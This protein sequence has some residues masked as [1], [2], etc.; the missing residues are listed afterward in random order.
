MVCEGYPPSAF[1][2]S[3]PK[4]QRSCDSAQ[5]SSR[6]RLGGVIAVLEVILYL[7]VT[8]AVSH[9]S[10]GPYCQN[11]VLGAFC[12]PSSVVARPWHFLWI[13]PTRPGLFGSTN[14]PR[15]LRRRHGGCISPLAWY[16]LPKCCFGCVLRSVRCRGVSVALSMDMANATRVIWV[17]EHTQEVAQVSRWLYP[18][19]R[20]VHTAKMVF[21]VRFVF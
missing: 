17:D 2:P 4:Q 14:T 13:W 20:M 15:R 12:V 7:G 11:A 5:G 3:F 19:A 21:W 6:K 16:I 18:T 9:R 1:E 8:V 10:H